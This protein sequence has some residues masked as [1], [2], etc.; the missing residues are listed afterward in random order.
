MPAD[1]YD[2]APADARDSEV[3]LL[4][5]WGL[6]EEGQDP[7]VAGARWAES[8]SYDR[9]FGDLLGAL[10]QE[11]SQVQKWDPTGLQWVDYS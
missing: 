3:S 6:V 8:A 11:A 10:F 5:H 9:L 7:F 4:V 2:S 1:V